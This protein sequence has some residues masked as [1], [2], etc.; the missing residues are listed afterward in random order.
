MMEDA[1]CLPATFASWREKAERR[2]LLLKGQ[3]MT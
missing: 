2:E 1:H 3:A